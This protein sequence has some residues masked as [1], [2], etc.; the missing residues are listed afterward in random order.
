MTKILAFHGK[1]DS[2]KNTLCNFIHGYQLKAFGLIDDFD[3]S[4]EG[5]LFVTMAIKEENG[6]IIKSKGEIDITRM[7]IEFAIWAMDNIWPFVKHYAFATPL[8]EMLIGLFNIPK[9]L[10]YGT[11]EEKNQLTQYKWEDMPVKIKGKTGFMSGREF[12]QY[13]G[14]DIARKIYS[15]IWVDRLT[16]DIV[17]E[18]PMLAVISDLRFQNELDAIQKIDGKVIK[19]TRSISNDSHESEN[20]IVDSSQFDAI[21]DNQNMTIEESCQTLAKLIDEWGWANGEIV[22]P[23]PQSQSHSKK[24]TTSVK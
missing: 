15:D 4:D 1:K 22:L 18:Q 19:L 2:G 21:I 9:E 24:F 13:F 10:L 5:K 23:Q 17:A 11:N 12:M 3:I 14:T 16:K 8:K 7:D 6:K 20:A